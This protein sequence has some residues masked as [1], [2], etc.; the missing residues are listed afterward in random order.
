MSVSTTLIYRLKLNF[1]AARSRVSIFVLKIRV[2]STNQITAFVNLGNFKN[3]YYLFRHDSNIVFIIYI[4]LH[5]QNMKPPCDTTMWY[6]ITLRY[7]MVATG[8]DGCH[9]VIVSLN[10]I[11]QFD[12]LMWYDRHEIPQCDA[13]CD[14]TAVRHLDVIPRLPRFGHH[15]W[16][17]LGGW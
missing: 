1:C 14:R 16:G 17:I 8:L 4:M 12:T 3:Q 11:P 2:V 15:F 9:H 5:R 6:P 7:H 10:L 13:P